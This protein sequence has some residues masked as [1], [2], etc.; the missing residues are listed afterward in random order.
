MSNALKF[1]NY[2]ATQGDRLIERMPEGR[3]IEDL[4]RLSLYILAEDKRQKG[5]IGNCTPESLFQCILRAWH[6]DLDLD[7]GDAHL[8]PYGNEC[9]LIEDYKGLI[10]LIKRSGEVTHIK[11]DVVRDGDQIE[12]QRATTASDR[13]L[14]HR[15]APFN[16]GEIIGAYALFHMATGETEFEVMNRAEI[17]MVRSK[18]AGG[19][20]MWKDFFSEGAKKAVLRRGI[21]TL[22]LMP[23]DKRQ[24][25]ESS[26]REFQA[27]GSA[28]SRDL[29]QMFSPANAGPRNQLAA[30]DAQLATREEREAVAVERLPDDFEDD[31]EIP[32]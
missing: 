30:G 31:E 14:V 21:K 27:I 29:N 22:E 18:A 17:D 13:Y 32:F 4:K 23:E 16:S 15:P 19:S 25:L 6:L 10:K 8:V 26:A 3:T 1:S 2:L 5:K 20:L 24:L 12:Y 7:L 9:T 11:A 28:P